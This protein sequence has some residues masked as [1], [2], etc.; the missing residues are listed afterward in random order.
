[1]C[2]SQGAQ[3]HGSAYFGEGRGEIVRDD[4]ACAGDETRLIDCAASTTHNCAHYE[5]ASVTC[6]SKRFY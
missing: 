4:V 1:M 5:D 2:C 6:A 3:A